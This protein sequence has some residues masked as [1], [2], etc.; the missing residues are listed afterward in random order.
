M[1]ISEGQLKRSQ[2]VA[3]FGPVLAELLAE[4]LTGY[5]RIEP[6]D[7]VVLE[8]D[9]AGVLTFNSGVPVAAYHTASDATGEAAL[10]ELSRLGPFSIE[11]YTA[12]TAVLNTVQETDA[13]LI[14][15]ERPA[16][17]LAGDPTLADRTRAQAS[18][19]Q[20]DRTREATEE[21]LISFL[22]D[23]KR[24]EQIRREAKQQARRR[25]QRWG[26]DAELIDEH[27]TRTDG[28]N[29]PLE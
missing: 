10:E 7:S 24:I 4:Q 6:G 8:A 28:R 18:T 17:L 21:A 20:L 9:G 22:S 25:A 13:A 11:V 12:S 14:P 3:E 16:E 29:N 23:E 1:N 15:P 26:L 5:S 19:A 2:V 27:T